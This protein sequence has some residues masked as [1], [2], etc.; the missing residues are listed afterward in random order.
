MHDAL[1]AIKVSKVS[2]ATEFEDFRQLPKY[3]HVPL[4]VIHPSPVKRM[5]KPMRPDPD[6]EAD[7]S[8]CRLQQRSRSRHE[9]PE[10]LMRAPRDDAAGD[11]KVKPKASIG[12][13]TGQARWGQKGK[14]GGNIRMSASERQAEQQSKFE[15]EKAKEVNANYKIFQDALKHALNNQDEE[16]VAHDT[17]N[18]KV[19]EARMDMERGL[20]FQRLNKK[21]NNSE[22]SQL[23]K[24][25]F[26]SI[27]Q[28]F[29]NLSDHK[30]NEIFN[31]FTKHSDSKSKAGLQKE[32]DPEM[33]AFD[34]G[35]AATTPQRSR[36]KNMPNISV[37]VNKLR[38]EYE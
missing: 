15:A 34:R 38:A 12:F 22:R 24:G 8:P 37:N 16:P 1:D 28:T 10:S 31:L 6:F 33:D 29:T 9:I 26:H 25:H 21:I 27:L 18:Y 5:A 7:A 14:K 4:A 32:N 11:R 20:L 13:G 17:P 19:R 36:K 35:R 23:E 2:Q 3:S 30:C